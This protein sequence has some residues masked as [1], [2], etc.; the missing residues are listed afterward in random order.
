MLNCLMYKL[1]YYRFGEMATQGMRGT[2]FDRARNYES[3]SNG[4]R[5]LRSRQA[6]GNKMVELTYLEEAFTSEHWIVR[7]YRV[8]AA[9]PLRA[10]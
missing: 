10:C 7:V 6:V 2:G 4:A 3:L 1:C 8:C 9:P 5:R